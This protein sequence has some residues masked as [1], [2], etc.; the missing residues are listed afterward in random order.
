MEQ[1]DLDTL[2]GLAVAQGLGYLPER[3]PT[4]RPSCPAC[5]AWYPA[6][7]SALHRHCPARPSAA[8]AHGRRSGRAGGRKCPEM[9]AFQVKTAEKVGISRAREGQKV[10]KTRG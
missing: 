9:S 1:L 6:G 7:I 4:P 8:L 10:S 5:G 3:I 2:R